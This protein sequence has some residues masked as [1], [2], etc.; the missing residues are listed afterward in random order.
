M[1]RKNFDDLYEEMQKLFS[2][3]QDMG[4]DVASMARGMPVDVHEEDGTFVI[5]AD[6]PGVEKEDINLRADENKVEIS[7]ESKT[8]I[9]EENEKYYRQERSS[10][11]FRRTVKWPEKVD[12][13]TIEASYDEG[14]LSVEAE[15]EQMNGRDIDVE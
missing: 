10:R 14:V 15:R 7:A 3:F 9:K 8:E 13:E 2:E 4:K 11:A 12:A 6:L 5:E 1:Q